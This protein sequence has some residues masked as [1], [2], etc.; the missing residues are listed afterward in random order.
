MVDIEVSPLKGLFTIKTTTIIEDKE[1][2]VSE[3]LREIIK[4]KIAGSIATALVNNFEVLPLHME[5]SAL[6]TLPAREVR[7]TMSL[8]DTNNLQEILDRVISLE[9]IL[10]TL[11]DSE[12]RNI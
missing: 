7:T 11:I 1:L 2:I 9:Q 3:N 10:T 12:E 8:I 5:S 6:S 4:T